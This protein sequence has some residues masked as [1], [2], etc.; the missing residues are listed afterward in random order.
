M[1]HA[2]SPRLRPRRGRVLPAAAALLLGA[3]VLAAC[4]SDAKAAKSGAT[5]TTKAGIRGT[6]PTLPAAAE[7]PLHGNLE[8]TGVLPLSLPKA[9]GVCRDHP[10]GLPREYVVRGAALGRYGFI[11][12]FGAT[13]VAGAGTVPANIKVY[14]NTVGLESAQTGTGVIVS[15]DQQSVTFDTNLAG[16]TGKSRNGAPI[17]SNIMRGHISGTLRCG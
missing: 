2:S 6:V 16:G 1:T 11:A 13:A 10:H 8:M 17:P 12:V 3:A 9:S 14:V 5:A 4:G 15:A 7:R